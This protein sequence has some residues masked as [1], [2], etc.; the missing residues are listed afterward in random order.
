MSTPVRT[1]SEID[2]HA[3]RLLV[4]EMG[5]ADAARFINQLTAGSGD[6]TEER[7]ELFKDLTVEDIVRQIEER[8]RGEM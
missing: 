7:K 5:P 8:T 2:D 6:Y 4:R 3:V 1:L